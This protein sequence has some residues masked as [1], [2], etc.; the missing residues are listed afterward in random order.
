MILNNSEGTKVAEFELGNVHIGNYKAKCLVFEEEY[1]DS[2][3]NKPMLKTTIQKLVSLQGYSIVTAN[4]ANVSLKGTE[5]DI[6]EQL[7]SLGIQSSKSSNI[8]SKKAVEVFAKADDNDPNFINVTVIV[9]EEGK[10]LTTVSLKYPRTHKTISVK[11]II[12]DLSAT[13]EFKSVLET[14]TNIEFKG[15]VL[16][17]DG[18]NKILKNK[19]KFA[20]DVSLRCLW[21]HLETYPITDDDVEIVNTETTEFDATKEYLIKN[22]A[23]EYI[24]VEE[25]TVA[26]AEG[27]TYYV[28]K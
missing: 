12:E 4:G 1:V 14:G 9:Y 26:F 16:A 13:D 24:P 17:S 6:I 8:I 5:A 18:D 21:E 23:G 15:L 11:E 10:S 20:E 22:E 25:G 19:V 28:L 7:R 27:V 2:D 3:G